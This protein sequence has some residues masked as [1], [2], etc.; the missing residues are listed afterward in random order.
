MKGGC[1]ECSWDGWIFTRDDKGRW[2]AHRCPCWLARQA[3]KSEAA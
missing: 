1:G 3:G 2:I